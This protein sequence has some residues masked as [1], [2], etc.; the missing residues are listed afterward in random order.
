MIQNITQELKKSGYCFPVKIFEAI[1]ADPKTELEV[2]LPAQ[3]ITLSATGA[4]EQFEIND[5]KKDNLLNGFDD[6]DYLLNMNAEIKDFAAK[7]PL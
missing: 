3:T 2:D 4:Q 5:Y 1:E 6:I 7:A